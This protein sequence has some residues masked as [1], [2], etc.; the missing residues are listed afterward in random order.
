MTSATYTIT[1]PATAANIAEFKALDDGTVATLTL[2]NAQVLFAQGNNIIVADASGGIVFFKTNLGYS[3]WDVLN[4]TIKAKYTLYNGIPEL[5]AVEESNI[6]V[7]TGEETEPTE[8][9][10]ADA[11]EANICRHYTK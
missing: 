5:T 11:T 3:Q 6:T 1:A 9:A 4:G 8:F 2:T 7:T 10:A